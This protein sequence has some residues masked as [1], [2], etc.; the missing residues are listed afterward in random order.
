MF[1][2]DGEYRCMVLDCQFTDDL[3]GYNQ[4]L[5]VRKRNGLTGF[6]RFYRGAQTGIADHRSDHDIYRTHRHHFRYRVR[7]G[8]Y[9]PSKWIAES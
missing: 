1:A 6:D 9:L 8:P 4:R 3:S 5:F 2:I 7:A